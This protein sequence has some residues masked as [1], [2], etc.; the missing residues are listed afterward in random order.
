MRWTHSDFSFSVWVS[1][2]FVRIFELAVLRTVGLQ[3]RWR[4]HLITGTYSLTSRHG[5]VDVFHALH[6]FHLLQYN[7]N[8]FV[9][10]VGPTTL[11][12]AAFFIS[13]PASSHFHR[14][15]FQDAIPHCALQWFLH[16]PFQNAS[17]WSATEVLLLCR[18]RRRPE[19]TLTAGTRNVLTTFQSM[20][21]ILLQ[22]FCNSFWR[23]FIPV[24]FRRFSSRVY[25][26]RFP[27]QSPLPYG[28][29]SVTGNLIVM[30]ILHVNISCKFP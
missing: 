4:Q 25:P 2:I 22:T 15:C 11:T 28:G 19:I 30:N 7:C 27:R 14:R 9:I 29:P 1:C 6:L 23:G 16:S 20:K 18:C 26:K 10:N 17:W 21:F 5:T 24:V 8:N 3:F 13:T 12:L